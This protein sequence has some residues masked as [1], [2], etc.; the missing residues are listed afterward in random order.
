MAVSIKPLS[1]QSWFKIVAGGKVIHIDPVEIKSF[2]GIEKELEDM[3]DI[4]LITHSH[5]DHCDPETIGKIIKPETIIIGT[6]SCREKI[7]S[8]LRVIK[9]GE[10]ITIDKIKIKAVQAYNI[11]KHFHPKDFGVG[12]LISVDD[13]IIYHAGDTDLIPEMGSFGIV[14]L[15]LLPIG[16]NYTMDINEA[17]KAVSVIKPEFIIPMHK[18]EADPLKFKEAAGKISGVNVEVLK[19]GEEFIL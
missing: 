6:E 9:A 11:G 17:V 3:A 12:Y 10:E 1:G 19:P 4:I 14:D 18:L 5:F 15:A 7:K 13:K 2:Q 8:G 16:G